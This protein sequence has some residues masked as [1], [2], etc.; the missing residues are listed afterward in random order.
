MANVFRYEPYIDMC[1]ASL[2]Q[3]LLNYTRSGEEVNLHDLIARYAYDTMFATTVGSS[4]GFLANSLDISKLAEAMENWKFLAILHGSYMRFHP[5]IAKVLHM[6]NYRRSVERQIAHHLGT[7]INDSNLSALAQMC[8]ALEE[9]SEFSS[10]NIEAC[11]VIIIAGAD[12]IISQM[13]ACLYYIYR[14]DTLLER[15]RREI[16]DANLTQPLK[17]KELILKKPEMP[18]LHAVFQETLRLHQPEN[19]GFTFSTP[20]DGM[21]FRDEY[22]PENVSIP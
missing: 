1:N 6:F 2:L 13:V 11:I 21:I 14:D 10:H 4:P 18:L 9:Q 5:I 16:S 3:A 7:N 15:L 20:T 22:V 12:P 19:A 8:K 17:L